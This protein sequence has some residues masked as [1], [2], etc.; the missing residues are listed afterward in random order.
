VISLLV[1]GAAIGL[2]ATR[3]AG[4]AASDVTA[5]RVEASMGGFD[6][7]VLTATVGSEI[8]ID[9]IDRDTSMHADG[10]GVHSFHI[11]SLKVHQ[12]VQPESDLVF[13]F[14]AP[15]APGTY[16]FYCDTC[17]GGKENPAM[18]GTLTVTA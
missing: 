14:S 17:C 8:K 4:P 9:L 7:G 18:H 5:I 3:L 15:T 2:V 12:T 16:D 10:G 6:P 11:D 13:S 1:G